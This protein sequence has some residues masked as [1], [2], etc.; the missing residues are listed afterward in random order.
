M[1]VF[2]FGLGDFARTLLILRATQLLTPSSGPARA[3]GVAMGLYALHNV[4]FAVVSYP[5]GLL[6]D[7][8]RPQRLLLLGYA[9]GTLTAV[10]AAVATPSLPLLAPV[11][12]AG[13]LTLAFEDTL[14][15]TIVGL[16]TSKEIRGT[17]YGVLATVNGVGD[18]FSSSAIGVAWSAL[19]APA[20][21]VIAAIFCLGGTLLLAFHNPW[22]Q[23]LEAV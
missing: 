2:I 23:D 13:G 9:L 4:V 12:L 21:F 22:A 16:E 5:I 10:L 7:R 18:L 1:A 6:A 17:G 8:L 20:A 3:A 15:G 19:G 14:E 11:F